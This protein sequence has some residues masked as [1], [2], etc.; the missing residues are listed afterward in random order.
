MNHKTINFVHNIHLSKEQRYKIHKG[1]VIKAIGVSYIDSNFSKEVFCIY[2]ILFNGLNRSIENTS[3]GYKIHLPFKA[4][5]ETQDVSDEEWRKM[6]NKKMMKFYKQRN[7]G[8]SSKCLLDLKDGGSK[9]ISYREHSQIKT[10]NEIINLNHYVKI[11]DL[12]ELKNSIIMLGNL[13]TP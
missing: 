10:K 1:E 13:V 4:K 11:D 5:E 3:Q 7:P 6:S 12:Q 8:I 9:Q 2:E